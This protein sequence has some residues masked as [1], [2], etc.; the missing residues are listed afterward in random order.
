MPRDGGRLPVAAVAWPL[1]TSDVENVVAKAWRR[2][3]AIV[4]VF[5]VTVTPA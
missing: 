3:A 5:P 4:T 1:L 2:P